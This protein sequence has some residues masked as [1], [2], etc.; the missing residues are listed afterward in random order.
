VLGT[1]G[2]ALGGAAE[3]VRDR[4]VASTRGLFAHA[5]DP[6]ARTLEFLGDPGLFGPGSATWRVV[7]DPAVFV[8]GLRALLVQA[9]HPEVVAGVSDHSRYRDDP[10]GRL[11]R[12]SSYV[13]ATAFGAMPEVDDAIAAVRHA[14]V[15]VRGT[16]HRG[17]DYT[18]STPVFAAWVHNTLTEAFLVAYQTYSATPLDPAEAD[19]YVAE[20]TRVGALLGADPM[21]T[22]AVE[23]SR[24][25]NEHPDLAPSPGQREAIRFLRNPPLPP[26]VRVAYVFVFWAAAATLE[27]QMRA[28]LGIR[29]LP[30]G[31]LVGKAMVGFLRWSLG[32][33][34]AW[35]VALV[36]SGA[37]VPPGRFRE[38]ITTRFVGADACGADAPGVG[39]TEAEPTVG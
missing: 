9:A 12:T 15:P 20:Q 25:V 27:P 35:H 23:L 5:P 22:T 10:L 8:G 7:G 28:R 36:R 14:H 33:S 17:R 39:A 2:K 18:A 32:Y 16:S 29:I 21:P 1:I 19:R 13:T 38:P 6:L 26:L 34:P 37:P 24:W 30:G 4:V 3:V 31:V 11:S